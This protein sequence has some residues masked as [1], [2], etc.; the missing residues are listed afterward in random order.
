V[1]LEP[2]G[3][4][5]FD[6]LPITMR[7]RVLRVLERLAQWPDV[8]WSETLRREWKGH[9]RICSGDWRDWLWFGSSTA[10]KCTRS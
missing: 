5:D 10:R 4:V 7:A 3:Q 6:E 9:Y 8:L 2:A 1:L